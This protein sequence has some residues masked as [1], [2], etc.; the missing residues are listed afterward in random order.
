MTVTS[1]AA[2]VFGWFVNLSTVGGFIGWWVMNCTY[3]FF[4]KSILFP[5]KRAKFTPSHRLR[6]QETG[7][8]HE[9]AL[10]PQSSPAI[11]LVVG[12]FLGNLLPHHLWS[13]HMAQ[14][15]HFCVHYLL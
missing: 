11:S 7:V 10:L 14:V 9:G 2:T 8:R 5:E 4:C 3:L 13:P 1:G 6:V 15:G 12:Y